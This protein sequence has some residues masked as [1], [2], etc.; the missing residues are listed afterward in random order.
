MTEEEAASEAQLFQI[1][2]TGHEASGGQ[3]CASHWLPPPAMSLQV[4]VRMSEDL[5]CLLSNCGCLK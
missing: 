3:G 2:R 5:P 1:L 4:T